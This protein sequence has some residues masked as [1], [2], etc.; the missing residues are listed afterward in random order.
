MSIEQLMEVQLAEYCQG[1]LGSDPVQ[2]QCQAVAINFKSN[3]S[4]AKIGSGLSE[5][6]LII[7]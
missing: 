3:F 4:F 7:T 2:H 5:L 1:H 6:D